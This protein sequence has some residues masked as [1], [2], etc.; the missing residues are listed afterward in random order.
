[1]TQPAAPVRVLVVDDDP[2]VL[3]ALRGLLRADPALEVVATV[4]DGSE[5]LAAV[6]RFRPDV[7]LMDARMRRVSAPEVLGPLRRAEPGVRVVV[8]SSFL[9]RE[10]E[11]SVLLAGADAFLPKVAPPERFSAE[12]R[13]V[14]GLGA[15]VHDVPLTPREREVARR[16]ADGLSNRAIARSLGLTES[17]T[18]TYV[19]RLLDKTG[20]SS[21][22]ELAN[23]VNAGA[24]DVSVAPREEGTRSV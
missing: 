14:A 20:A 16:I 22:V 8:M 23:R 9:G 24:V 13:R 19:S 6:R 2:L 17:T 21:R 11:A 12:I 3:I 18:R 10:A 1:M 5:V 15:S 7:V 4:D